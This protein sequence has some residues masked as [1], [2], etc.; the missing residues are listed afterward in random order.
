LEPRTRA[1]LHLIVSG[2]CS[3]PLSPSPWVSLFVLVAVPLLVTS[4][5]GRDW[6]MKW[7][8]AVGPWVLLVAVAAAGISRGSW[9]A[10]PALISTG[11][12][13][14]FA[15]PLVQAIIFVILYVTFVVVLH[16]RPASFNAVRYRHRDEVRSASGVAPSDRTGRG[17]V[18]AHKFTG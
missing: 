13:A 16:R 12:I 3:M 9:F 1:S 18:T 8:L 10:A 2:F 6:L 7:P 15:A 4:K 11:G 5:S 17:L 14:L